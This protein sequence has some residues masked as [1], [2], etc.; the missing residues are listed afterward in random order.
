MINLDELLQQELE[1]LKKQGLFRDMKRIDSMQGP[2]VVI[3]NREYVLFSSNN[4][5]GLASHPEVIKAQVQASQEFG[6]G[7]C[8]SR[9]I[10][11]NMSLHEKLERKI[12]DFKCTESAILFPTGYMA[13][14]G[15]ISALV[16]EGD[17]VVCDKLN[18]A[19]II[20]GVRMSGAMLRVYPHRN[21]ERLEDILKNASGY[22]RRLIIS[23]GVFSM[24]G[25]IAP[26]PEIIKIS[27]RFNAILMLD[28]AHATGVL[29]KTGKGTCE[30][31]GIDKGV[32]IQMGTFSKAF[33]N[34]GG[35]IAGPLSLIEYIRNRARSFIYST[36]LPPA[37]V[38][39]CI[40][41]IEIAERGTDLRKRLW[42]NVSR[43]RD[44]LVGLDFDIMD[45]K[46]QI[47][48]VSTGDISSTMK[49]SESL[50]NNGIYAPGIRP[51]T[52]P[53]NKCRIRVSLMATHSNDHIDRAI[54]TFGKLKLK[55]KKAKLQFKIKKF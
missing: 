48:P 6:A 54:E 53:K 24:D 35:F 21:P 25:D 9:L 39:G 18:H 7:S 17:L 52:V 5:L 38:G 44:A 8:A 29:G 27:Q 22:K 36:A 4:Y 40:K 50:L 51:P 43:L 15:T 33:G 19:S 37:I 1:G 46:T 31:F 26:L 20:D 14:V 10:S 45:T 12:A 28:D 32:D 42:S 30:Y 49:A 34:L 11:G 3:D 2:I 16:G 47:I 41:A 55:S 13:N 23:D